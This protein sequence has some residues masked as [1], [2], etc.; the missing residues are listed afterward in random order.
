MH[1]RVKIFTDNSAG[2]LE[3]EVN[4]FLESLEKTEGEL[5]SLQM[6]ATAAPKRE[7][8]YRAPYIIY[9]ATLVYKEVK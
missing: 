5:V 4:K 9:T 3:I 8:A 6:A 2:P 7:F 1:T